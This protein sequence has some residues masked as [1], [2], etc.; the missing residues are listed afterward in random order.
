MLVILLLSFLGY[1]Q[2]FE[3]DNAFQDQEEPQ[4]GSFAQEVFDFDQP[5]QDLDGAGNPG[6]PV[7]IDNWVYLLP[8]IGIGIAAFFLFEKRNLA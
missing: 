1:A 6:D 4:N 2:F 7:H 3:S 8:V 5:D